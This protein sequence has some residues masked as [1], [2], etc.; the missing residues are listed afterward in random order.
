MRLRKNLLTALMAAA[1][2]VMAPW[3]ISLLSVPATLATLGV[4]LAA[5]LLG[6]WRGTAAVGLYLLIGAVGMPVFAG[7]SGGIQHLFGLTGGFLWG[8]LPCAFVAGLLC[9]HGKPQMTP[10]WLAIGTMVLYAIGVAW[11]VW[12]AQV[13][14]ATA[15]LACVTYTLPGEAIKIMAATGLIL[16]LK[17]RVERLTTAGI[18]KQ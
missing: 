6:P 10:L 16:P 11:V 5:G 2:C 18:N 14:L 9:R 4:Y 15:L 13:N 17:K 7:F 12:Q 1:L 8:Y 3:A